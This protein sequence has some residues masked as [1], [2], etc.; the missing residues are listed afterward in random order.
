[1]RII[2]SFYKHDEVRFVSHLDMQRLFQRAFR[3]A[4]L[5]L[6]YSKGFNPHPLLSFA[7]ALSVGYTSECEYFDVFLDEKI[8]ADEF[9]SRV[10]AVLPEGVAVTKAVDAGE[11]KTSLTTLMRSADYFARL[12]FDREVTSDELENALASLLTGEIFVEKKTKG[13]MKDVDIRPLLISVNLIDCSEGSAILYIKGKLT[14]EGG[15]P[16]ELLFGAISEK[17][18]AS[19]V[20]TVNR[21]TIEMDW[22]EGK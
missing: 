19:A 4:G 20:S 15:L 14:A 22:S 7:T 17:V 16:L 2:A 1:M 10:N 21:R 6:S 11:M 13:G 5:P 3:R 9:R 8:D 18:S 12:D